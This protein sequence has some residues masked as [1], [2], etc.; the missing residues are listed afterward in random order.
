MLNYE[1]LRKLAEDKAWEEV[2]SLWPVYL[3]RKRKEAFKRLAD[4][5]Y[6]QYVT[7]PCQTSK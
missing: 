1:A 7:P 5:Y 2:K 6:M 3:P 4:K